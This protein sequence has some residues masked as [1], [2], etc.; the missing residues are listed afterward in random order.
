M[1]KQLKAVAVWS[2]RRGELYRKNADRKKF[3]L[4]EPCNQFTTFNWP[5]RGNDYLLQEIIALPFEL[6]KVQMQFSGPIDH[7]NPKGFAFVS[8]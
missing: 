8:P 6:S 3:L 5:A 4:S 7:S 2:S 1:G